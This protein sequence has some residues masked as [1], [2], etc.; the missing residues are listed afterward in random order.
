MK[1][2]KR[3]VLPL[4][5]NNP[6]AMLQAWGR[7]AGKLPSRKGPGGVGQ[8]VAEHEPATCPGGQEGHK[9]PSSC[10]KQCGQQDQESNRPLMLS[11]GEAAPRSLRSG[12]GPSL[13]ERHGGAAAHPRKSSKLVK[14]LENK[15]CE[16]LLKELR[17]FSLE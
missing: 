6:H 16:E 3:H 12:L 11:T 1:K 14:G 5:V 2:A 17:C 15:S 7:V 9:H 4:G 13:Q 8:D 10:Q